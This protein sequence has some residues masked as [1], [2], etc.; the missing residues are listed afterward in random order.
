MKIMSNNW[1]LH[2]PTNEFI[3]I[4]DYSLALGILSIKGKESRF[5]N[6]KWG[7][8]Y[9]NDFNIYD[10]KDCEPIP[11]IPKVLTKCSFLDF[12]DIYYYHNGFILKKDG[13]DLIAGD[14]TVDDRCEYKWFTFTPIKWVHQLQNLF[15]CMYNIELEINL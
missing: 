9:D 1:F 14:I 3:C 12:E 8:F 15:Y 10:I 2:K 4:E 13:K 6:G 7:V 11:L 5:F